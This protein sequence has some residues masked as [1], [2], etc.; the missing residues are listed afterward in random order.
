MLATLLAHSKLAIGGIARTRLSLLCPLLVLGAACHCGTAVGPDSDETAAGEP[1]QDTCIATYPHDVTAGARCDA[2][3]SAS[4]MRSADLE[5][6]AALALGVVLEDCFLTENI[7]SV[8][9]EQG[10]ATRFAL[11]IESP[12]SVECVG[13][14]LAAARHE[15]LGDLDCGSATRSTIR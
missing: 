7:L 2:R 14:H 3:P 15:C 9:F 8:D 11:S 5:E 13:A 4:C 6:A 10:C 1:P 12:G